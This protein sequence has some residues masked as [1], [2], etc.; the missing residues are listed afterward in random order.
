MAFVRRLPLLAALLAAVVVVQT[1]DL[2]AC[3]D[4]AAAVEHAES[5]T[6]GGSPT[7]GPHSEHGHDGGLD[8]DCL[9]HIVFASTAVP[10]RVAV[11]SA[12]RAPVAEWTETPP[13][14]EP[15]G[16]DHVPLG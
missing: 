12:D 1:T 15:S 10:P 16:L 6:P 9:C 2:V 14:V 8:A 7:D 4:E 13:E 5:G 3:A 11:H